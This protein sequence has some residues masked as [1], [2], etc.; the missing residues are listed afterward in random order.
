MIGERLAELRKDRGMTQRELAKAL[1]VSVT[2]ISGYENDRNTPSDEVSVAIAKIFNISLDYL[3]G[4][5]DEELPLIRNNVIVLPVGFPS[6]RRNEVL[7]FAGF[8][9]YRHKN[10]SVKASDGT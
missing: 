4:A 2:T 5:I 7:E 10:K 3:L 1:S 6:R 9:A 8:L